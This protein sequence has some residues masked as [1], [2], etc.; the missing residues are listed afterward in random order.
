MTAESIQ[1]LRRLAEASDE[2]WFEKEKLEHGEPYSDHVGRL[3]ASTILN[4][5]DE[6]ELANRKLEKARAALREALHCE[7]NAEYRASSRNL[8]DFRLIKDVLR[9]ALAELEGK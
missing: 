3:P 2:I 6:I 4:L 1:N 8:E 7:S 9:A 5:L